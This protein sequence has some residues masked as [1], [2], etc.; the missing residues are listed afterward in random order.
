MKDR[1]PSYE[2]SW[3]RLNYDMT[4]DLFGRKRNQVG[5]PNACCSGHSPPPLDLVW[6]GG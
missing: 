3:I 2:K 5:I 6:G 4:F 1:R